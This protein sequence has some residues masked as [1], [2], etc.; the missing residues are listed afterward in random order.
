MSEADEFTKMTQDCIDLVERSKKR[1][2]TLIATGLSEDD[3]AC[4]AIS[5]LAQMV[6]AHLTIVYEL[7]QQQKEKSKDFEAIRKRIKGEE[8]RQNRNNSNRIQG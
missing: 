2:D 3:P 4:K 1:I 7:G 6:S 5:E 8:D